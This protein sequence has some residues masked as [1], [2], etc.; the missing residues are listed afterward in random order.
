[1][2]QNSNRIQNYHTYYCGAGKSKSEEHGL[3]IGENWLMEFYYSKPATDHSSCKK[4]EFIKGLFMNDPALVQYYKKD[5][6]KRRI[7]YNP[8]SS[9]CNQGDAGKKTMIR[10]Y[11]DEDRAYLSILIAQNR[12]VNLI[13][14]NL[15][16]IWERYHSEA[17]QYY[18]NYF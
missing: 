3:I 7:R 8:Y 2:L 16:Y 11:R 9:V 18:K 10:E 15:N 14:N 1:M 5:F 13:E 12:W 6:E 4:Y 17:M